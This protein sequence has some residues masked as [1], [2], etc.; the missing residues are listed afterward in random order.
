[1]TLDHRGGD[2]YSLFLEAPD[3]VPGTWQVLA[4]VRDS[5]GLSASNSKSF[6]VQ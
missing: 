6:L 2:L 4:T 1:V 5:T 3:S